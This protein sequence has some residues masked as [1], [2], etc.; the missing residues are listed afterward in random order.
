MILSACHNKNQK[1]NETKPTL[2]EL[3]YKQEYKLRIFENE[4]QI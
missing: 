3:Q 2:G 4:Q 1:E